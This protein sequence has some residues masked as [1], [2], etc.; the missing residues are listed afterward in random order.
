MSRGLRGR[1]TRTTTRPSGRDVQSAVLH[2]GAHINGLTPYVDI[3]VCIY[4]Y[5]YIHISEYPDV[6]SL[7][8]QRVKP[9]GLGETRCSPPPPVLSRVGV[10]P[11]ALQRCLGLRSSVLFVHVNIVRGCVFGLAYACLCVIQCEHSG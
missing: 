3:Y 9:A 2:H 4:I 6:T 10:D 11:V 1:A 5:I 7:A 8:L